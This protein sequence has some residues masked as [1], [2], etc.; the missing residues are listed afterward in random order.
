MTRRWDTGANGHV[1]HQCRRDGTSPPPPPVY[2]DMRLRRGAFK[3][4]PGLVHKVGG[5]VEDGFVY[6]MMSRDPGTRIV[7]A[8]NFDCYH[9]TLVH[10]GVLGGRQ[11]SPASPALANSIRAG[12]ASVS[13]Y[14]HASDS[15]KRLNIAVG[16]LVG[17]ASTQSPADLV[18]AKERLLQL[19]FVAG[20][21]DYLPA[22]MQLFA[23][24]LQT[25]VQQNKTRHE[26]QRHGA[27]SDRG[28]GRGRGGGGGAG[29]SGTA[30]EE[31]DAGAGAATGFLTCS[32]VGKPRSEQAVASEEQLT[33]LR[34]L[35][36]LDADLHTF[37]KSLFQSR[38]KREFGVPFAIEGGWEAGTS[39]AKG[40][41]VA[42]C[43]E[44]KD[45]KCFATSGR[46]SA[47][48]PP[49]PSPPPCIPRHRS[50][51]IDSAG[52]RTIHGCREIVC[53]GGCAIRQTP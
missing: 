1:A 35:H 25:R 4:R 36:H 27:R 17:K 23:K 6:G 18:T 39:G 13:D 47:E 10:S 43:G 2:A 48:L 26:A 11:K 32:N 41:P 28:R 9:G 33:Q 40:A 34:A 31:G 3:T 8:L 12:T 30:S 15:A 44:Q 7:S 53:W 46:Y 42:D 21:F 19:D 49:S 45:M 50:K 20:V 14:L 38:W 22:S 16:M 24:V 37:A 51:E 52:G 5:P 29:S